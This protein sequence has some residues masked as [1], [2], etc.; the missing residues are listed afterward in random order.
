V[1]KPPRLLAASTRNA[2]SPLLQYPFFVVCSGSPRLSSGIYL[3]IAA[4]G[5]LWV[6]EDFTLVSSF[7]HSTAS[8]HINCRYDCSALMSA[9]LNS[10]YNAGIFIPD[11]FEIRNLP[12][13]DNVSSLIGAGAVVT[14]KR[15]PQT[16]RR[17]ARR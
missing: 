7:A 2:V 9:K 3:R 8:A 17:S 5:W 12:K 10:T 13:N 11:D 1:E 4:L 15:R 14:A 6:I 16:R